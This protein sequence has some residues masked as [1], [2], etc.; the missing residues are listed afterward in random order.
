MKQRAMKLLQR[1]RELGSAEYSYKSLIYQLGELFTR[2]AHSEFSR[3]IDR[4][5]LDRLEEVL[6]TEIVPGLVQVRDDY[7]ALCGFAWD[8]WIRIQNPGV[9]AV[10]LVPTQLHY[11][12]YRDDPHAWLIGRALKANGRPGNKTVQT[13]LAAGTSKVTVLSAAATRP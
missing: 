12:P 5:V 8:D 3:K 10:E 4:A 6:E 7:V 1:G 2:L 13:R 11:N 9:A